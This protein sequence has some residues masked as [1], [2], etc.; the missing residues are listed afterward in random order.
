MTRYN[1]E[2]D[3][4]SPLEKFSENIPIEKEIDHYKF[5]IIIDGCVSSWGRPTFILFS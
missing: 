3:G 2:D 5:C 4:P 1:M